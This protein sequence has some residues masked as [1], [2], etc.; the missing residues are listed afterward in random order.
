MAPRSF[1]VW[2]IEYG[3]IMVRRGATKG[4]PQ[5][6]PNLFLLQARRILYALINTFTLA[7][8]LD[9]GSS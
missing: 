9:A 4:I 8:M 3:R 1:H 5:D 7:T 2:C 6:L